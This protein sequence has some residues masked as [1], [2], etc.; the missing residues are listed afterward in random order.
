MR[1]LIAAS[2]T[3]IGIGTGLLLEVAAGLPVGPLTAFG[4]L[5]GLLG[6][7]A[8]ARRTYPRPKRRLDPDRYPTRLV[9]WR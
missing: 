9:R 2:L 7:L 6:G 5:V 8:L 1:T 3:V 4:G